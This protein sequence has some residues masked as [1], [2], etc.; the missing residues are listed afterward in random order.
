MT[1]G[2]DAFE[3]RLKLF[4]FYQSMCLLNGLNLYYLDVDFGWMMTRA[5]GMVRS[6]VLLKSLSNQDG[7][8]KTK[9]LALFPVRL[10]WLDYYSY[11]NSGDE[12]NNV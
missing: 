10:Y 8:M 11:E 1:D 7:N 3:A 5:M 9:L 2:T 6:I 4:G 12:V